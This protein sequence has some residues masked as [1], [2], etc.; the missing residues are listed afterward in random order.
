M[1]EAYE[2]LSYRGYN[3]EISYD[4]DAE[5]PVRDWDTFGTFACRHRNYNLSCKEGEQLAK[6][7]GNDLDAYTDYFKRTRAVYLPLYLYDHSGITISTTPFSCRWDSG[8]VGFVF[9]TRDKIMTEYSVKRITQKVMD[10]V[11]DL[12]RSEVTTF[13]QYLRGEVFGYDVK[14][15]DG[16]I[17]GSCSGFYG[18]D[19]ETNGVLENARPEIDYAIREKVTAQIR[20]L[21][22]HIRHRVPLHKRTDFSHLHKLYAL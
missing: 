3:I 12:M 2:T 8:L 19:M 13:D 22:T 17:I 11:C 4:P 21:K 1:S 5:N 7:F 6:D 18:S 15:P 14:D 20:Q 9:A 16:E 10:K